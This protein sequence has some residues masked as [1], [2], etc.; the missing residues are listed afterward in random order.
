MP[1]ARSMHNLK[2]YDA[3]QYM[4]VS[5]AE[6]VNPRSLEEQ[7]HWCTMRHE[8]IGC[9]RLIVWL[10]LPVQIRAGESGTLSEEDIVPNR[11]SVLVFSR[12]GYVK[13]MPAD[14]FATQVSAHEGCCHRHL[15][16][17]V[18]HCSLHVAYHLPDPGTGPILSP[19]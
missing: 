8:C 3:W 2:T 5:I 9:R 10:C 14:L 18:S 15:V 11:P 7:L 19:F 1:I 4:R 17:S 12:K 13:R 6:L 16:L